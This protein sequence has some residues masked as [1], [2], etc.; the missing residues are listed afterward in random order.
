MNQ[1]NPRKL[2]R[3]KWTAATPVNREKHFMVTKV[4]FDEDG[5]VVYCELEAVMS[6]RTQSIDWRELKD[7]SRWRFGWR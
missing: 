6:K 3:S 1:I 4:E 7:V 2:M 5:T